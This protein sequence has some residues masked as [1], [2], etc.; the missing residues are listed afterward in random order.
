MGIVDIADAPLWAQDLFSRRDVAFLDTE[1]TGLG[2]LDEVIDI[3]VVDGTGRVLL[4][5]LVRPTQP[6]HPRARAVHGLADRLLA[7]Q[8]AWPEVHTKLLAALRDYSCI[9]MYNA[10]FDLR[11]I[12]QSCRRYAVAPL[13]SR[14][15]AHCAMRR[16]AQHTGGRRRKLGDALAAMR[17]RQAE[18]HRALADAEAC[19]LLVQ[20]LALEV[21]ATPTLL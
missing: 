1:T 9:V 4:N 11:L 12:D 8:P 15:E 16:Y 3:A 14:I 19:R 13:P 5:S 7:A 10:P 21:P 17:V 18:S 2:P 6:I 20:A